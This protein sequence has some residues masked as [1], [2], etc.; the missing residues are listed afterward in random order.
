[1]YSV[2]ILYNYTICGNVNFDAFA[3]VC[4]VQ[5]H[6]PCCYSRAMNRWVGVEATVQGSSTTRATTKPESGN[7]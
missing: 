7:M 1:M 6:I 4:N 3:A 5:S 2:L